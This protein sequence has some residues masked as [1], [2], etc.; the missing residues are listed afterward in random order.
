[1]KAGVA[2]FHLERLAFQLSRASISA[3]SFTERE[4]TSNEECKMAYATR[5]KME[6]TF[7][8]AS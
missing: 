8:Q 6:N 7:F 4:A 1:M 2:G 3:S 5:E